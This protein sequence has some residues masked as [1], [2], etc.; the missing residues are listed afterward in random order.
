MELFNDIRPYNDAEVSDILK[1]LSKDK[2]F[3]NILVKY[4][5]PLISKY[6]GWL[7]IPVVGLMLANKL[8]KIS[9]VDDFQQIVAKYMDKMIQETT[10][11]VTISGIDNL[12]KDKSYTF[13]SNHRDIALDPGLINYSLHKKGFDTCRIAIGDNLIDLPFVQDLM[14]LN[15]SFIVK[16]SVENRRQKLKELNKLSAYINSCIE[17][18]S[19][20]WIAQS[21][22]RAKDGN[23]ITES[24]IIKMLEL[25]HR[26]EEDSLNFTVEKLNIIPVSISYEYDPCDYAKAEELF[27]Y[28]RQGCYTKQENEDMT[29]I[30]MGIKGY[31]GNIHI[32]FGSK[33]TG[34]YTTAQEV[35]TAID[36]QIHSLYRCHPNNLYAWEMLK[37]TNQQE[38]LLIDE[39][40][41]NIEITGFSDEKYYKFIQRVTECNQKHLPWLLKMYAYPLINRYHNS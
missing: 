32:A 39:T 30:A 15:K 21:E 5:Y 8:K 7:L 9:K 6:C 4:N 19:S 38:K 23:D 2:A 1:R 17:T 10:D 36:K 18:N 13:I 35:A 3:H 24:A 12:D 40:K 26:K 20:L 14:R 16:R 29:S 28:D 27:E 37:K 31:K 41:A 34:N 25:T 33:V 11:S 22:G